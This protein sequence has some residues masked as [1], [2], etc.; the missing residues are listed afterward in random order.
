MT[1]ERVEKKLAKKSPRAQERARK[2]RE[3]IAPKQVLQ[4]EHGGELDWP[5]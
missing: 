3:R 2:K 1:H 4:F 5:N